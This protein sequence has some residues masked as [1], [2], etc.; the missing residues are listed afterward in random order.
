[1]RGVRREDEVVG[2]FDGSTCGQNRLVDVVV[3]SY[4]NPSVLKRALEP[5][6]RDPR[7]NLVVVDNCPTTETRAV[8]EDFADVYIPISNNIGFGRAC[9]RGVH[10]S[11]AEYL[12]FINPD[13]I[14]VPES[15]VLCVA[16]L[17]L[18][19]DIGIIG[20]RLRQEDGSPDLAA[21]RTIV[22]P[23]EAA[24]YLMSR[25][26]AS[27]RHAYHAPGVGLDEEGIV[28]AVNGAFMVLE[29]KRF[30]ALAGFDEDYWMYMEDV[31]LCVR[32]KQDLGLSTLYWPG[33]EALHLKSAI[34]GR[35][36]SA[37]LNL[38]FFLSAWIFYRKHQAQDDPP[39]LQA[40]VASGLTVFCVAR[41]VMDGLHRSLR[42]FSEYRTRLARDLR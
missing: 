22:K 4:R 21:K 24:L 2:G 12:A 26:R 34:S 13:V 41:I 40:A 16:Q 1:M 37:R 10:A 29:R 33:V 7:L 32:M 5:L 14:C 25:N 35:H 15:I 27:G 3:V 17:G 20:C 31:D 36:R 38:H 18:R 30:V 42:T 6:S 28:D 19:N 9:N 39:I 11:S 23:M 8:A